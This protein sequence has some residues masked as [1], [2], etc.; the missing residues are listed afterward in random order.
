[1]TVLRHVQVVQS[2][3]PRQRDGTIEGEYEVVDEP[4]GTLIHNPD[5]RWRRDP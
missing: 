3:G 1:V 2:G 4:P 5:S